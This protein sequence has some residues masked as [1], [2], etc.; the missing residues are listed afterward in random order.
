M[1]KHI[2]SGSTKNISKCFG[3]YGQRYHIRQN[4]IMLNHCFDFSPLFS[5][6][7][8]VSSIFNRDLDYE[9]KYINEKCFQNEMQQSKL[10]CDELYTAPETLLTTLKAMKSLQNITLNDGI[11]FVNVIMLS[12]YNEAESISNLKDD[13]FLFEF[14][15]Q[16]EPFINEL[17]SEDLVYTLIA[18]NKTGIPLH[19]SITTKI[20]DEISTRLKT[21][22]IYF[23]FYF[24][25]I[26]SLI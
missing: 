14:F 11:S 26:F 25:Q 15:Q 4:Q 8:S 7:R 22:T 24:Y 16:F 5:I 21:G 17:S 19:H 23:F 3:L 6:S 18:S 13:P 1:Y 20:F 12:L 2:L 10:Q 9:T